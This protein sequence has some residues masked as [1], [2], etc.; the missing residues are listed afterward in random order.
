MNKVGKVKNAGLEIKL[1][2][3]VVNRLRYRLAPIEHKATE[4]SIFDLLSNKIPR[5][6]K[7]PFA[8]D[9]CYEER[10]PEV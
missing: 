10:W 9:S 3:D 4:E 8:H 1:K 7:S 6:S 5:A 2:K